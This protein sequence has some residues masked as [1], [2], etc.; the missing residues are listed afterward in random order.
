M[1]NQQWT[2]LKNN[3]ANQ[4]SL[5]FAVGNP[6]YLPAITN[7]QYTDTHKGATRCRRNNSITHA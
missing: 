6:T 5:W 7:N 2:E 1:A 3:K 4:G